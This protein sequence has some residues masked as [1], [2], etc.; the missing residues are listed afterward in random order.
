MLLKSGRFLK[1]ND[2]LASEEGSVVF[3]A[4]DEKD[5]QASSVNGEFYSIPLGSGTPPIDYRRSMCFNRKY[6][7]DISSFDGS[8][9]SLMEIFRKIG[10]R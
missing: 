4:F 2:W 3:E 10:R 8:F 7:D 6:T 5:W 1:L 9:K